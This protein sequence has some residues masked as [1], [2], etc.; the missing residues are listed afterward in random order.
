MVR[1]LISIKKFIQ[2][3]F[4]FSNDY[5]K[6]PVVLQ[7]NHTFCKVCIISYQKCCI[8]KTIIQTRETDFVSCVLRSFVNGTANDI[9]TT[10]INNGKLLRFVKLLSEMYNDNL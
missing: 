3:Q 8:C 7:C 5:L 9:E 4:F 1:C 10:L 2:N 6:E